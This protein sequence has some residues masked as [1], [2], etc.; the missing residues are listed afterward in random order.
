MNPKGSLEWRVIWL[1]VVLV[2]LAVAILIV[3][4]VYYASIHGA[5][6]FSTLSNIFGGR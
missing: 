3:Y 5:S 4:A 1:I 2:S 6:P